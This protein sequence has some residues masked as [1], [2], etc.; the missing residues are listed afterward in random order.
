MKTKRLVGLFA[1]AS[2]L[3][4]GSAQAQITVGVAGPM[5]GQYASFGEQLRI[6]QALKRLALRT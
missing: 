6:A 5:S 2:L 3:A 4:A 1:A